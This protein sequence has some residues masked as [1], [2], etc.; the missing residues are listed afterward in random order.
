MSLR[1]THKEW[2]KVHFN[3]YTTILTCSCVTV[4]YLFFW[5]LLYK[6]YV[7]NVRLWWKLLAWQIN[8][9]SCSFF[10]L[11]CT[12]VATKD[13]FGRNFVV[14]WLYLVEGEGGIARARGWVTGERMSVAGRYTQH[15][16]HCT[17]QLNKIQNTIYKIQN[18]SQAHR[19]LVTL[20]QPTQLKIRQDDGKAISLLNDTIKFKAPS[21]EYTI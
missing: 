3:I 18:T 6:R 15:L 1:P 19:A 14:F 9:A 16:W 12:R 8:V 5:R 10:F 13:V 17:S 2:E 4:K 7:K 21:T 11:L 20:H